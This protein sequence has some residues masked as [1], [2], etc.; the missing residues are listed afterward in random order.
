VDPALSL[1]SSIKMIDFFKKKI[2]SINIFNLKKPLQILIDS[3][4]GSDFKDQ[5][6]SF[7]NHFFETLEVPLLLLVMPLSMVMVLLRLVLLPP[8]VILPPPWLVM[9]LT[10]L[11]LLLTALVLL[12]TSLVILPQPP[13]VGLPLLLPSLAMRLPMPLASLLLLVMPV[14]PSSTILAMFEKKAWK[15]SWTPW[16][17]AAE[18][19]WKENP[20][21]SDQS[22]ASTSSARRGDLKNVNL[23]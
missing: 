19:S 3:S 10:S 21:S 12:L 23:K 11:V 6:Y 1:F 9:L 16:P 13:L 20:L 22:L 8:L 7:I 14:V 5:L 4:S 2:F 17:V 15:R 18:V